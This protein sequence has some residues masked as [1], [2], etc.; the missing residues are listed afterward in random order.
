MA[1]V[2]Y[3]FEVIV[4]SDLD[5]DLSDLPF[6]CDLDHDLCY[7]CVPGDVDHDLSDLPFRGDLDHDL[8]HL[9]VFP[10]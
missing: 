3:Q 6:R 7:L 2:F 1:Y 5:H 9:C 4:T 8:C 10:R